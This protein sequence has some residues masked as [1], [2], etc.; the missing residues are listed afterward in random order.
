MSS[1]ARFWQLVDKFQPVKSGQPKIPP[2]TT[3]KLET[4]PKHETPLV[5]MK[6]RSNNGDSMKGITINDLVQQF[7]HLIPVCATV[8]AGNMDYKP[9]IETGDTLIVHAIKE[10]Q[11]VTITDNQDVQYN[12][13]INSSAKFGIVSNLDSEEYMCTFSVTELMEAGTL[14]SVVACLADYKGQNES[15]SFKQFEI[16]LLKEVVIAKK[17]KR[18]R[19][20]KAYSIA[21]CMTKYVQQEADIFFSNEPSGIQMYLTEI[22]QHASHLLPCRACMFLPQEYRS[23]LEDLA[24]YSVVI[25]KKSTDTSLLACLVKG[26]TGSKMCIEIST[27]IHLT[28]ALSTESVKASKQD[29]DENKYITLINRKDSLSEYLLKM[30]RKEHETQG[31]ITV[32]V[33]KLMF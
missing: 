20:I 16:L 5:Q 32:R 12:V 31:T 25:E 2:K 14:P 23:L 18:S 10:S 27:S 28:V 3:I 13:P 8:V 7:S 1:S 22:I 11:V 30:I 33:F 6:T 21:D 29:L 17:Y 19:M 26:S 9:T 15:M 4:K 24:T